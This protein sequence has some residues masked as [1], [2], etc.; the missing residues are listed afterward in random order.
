MRFISIEE[1]SS[2]ESVLINVSQISSITT[3]PSTDA[4]GYQRIV[5]VNTSDGKCVP[6][7]FTSV[8]HAIDYIQRAQSV[9]LSAP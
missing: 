8:E 2:T 7:K 6:T 9:S 4:V 5:H 1:H 3:T